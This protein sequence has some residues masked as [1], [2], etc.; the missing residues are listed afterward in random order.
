MRASVCEFIKRSESSKAPPL[1]V[2]LRPLRNW[3]CAERARG[4]TQYSQ[5][6]CGFAQ[7]KWESVLCIMA[8]KESP[9]SPL[10]ER[11]VFWCFVRQDSRQRCVHTSCSFMRFAGL[12]M[13]HL[14]QLQSLFSYCSFSSSNVEVEGENSKKHCWRRILLITTSKNLKQFYK[15]YYFLV[16]YVLLYF[17]TYLVFFILKYVQQIFYNYWCYWYDWTL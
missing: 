11:R 10:S 8:V 6:L 3:I 9:C 13:L 12:R 2:L 14:S 1:S 4:V 7:A 15:F 5:Y 17:S 16:K